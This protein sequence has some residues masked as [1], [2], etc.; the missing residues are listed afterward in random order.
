MTYLIFKNASFFSK[1]FVL[2]NCVCFVCT[3]ETFK[4][5]NIEVPSC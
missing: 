4:G 1:Q 3:K 5:V 2:G